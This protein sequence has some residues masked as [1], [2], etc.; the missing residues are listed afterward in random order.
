ME[1]QKLID[2]YLKFLRLNSY[3]ERTVLR[4][5]YLLNIFYDYLI[6]N[7]ITDIT[8]ISYLNGIDPEDILNSACYYVSKGA[9]SEDTITMY[10]SVIREF[11]RYIKKEFDIGNDNLIKIFGLGQRDEN[12]FSNKFKIFIEDQLNKKTIKPSSQ[13]VPFTD[14]QVKIIVNYCNQNLTNLSADI[15]IE[16]RYYNRCVKSLAVKLIA[17]IGVSVETLNKIQIG[18]LDTD[19][20]VISIS[21]Y[22]IRLP[23]WLRRQ[24]DDFRKSILKNSANNFPLFALYNGSTISQPSILGQFISRKLRDEPDVQNPYSLT[25]L[26]K[27]AIMQLIDAELDRDMIIE[28]TGYKD[29][30]FSSCKQI[31]DKIDEVKNELKINNAI[32]QLA[33][34]DFL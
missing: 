16:E 3:S 21:G 2:E 32:K 15:N 13:G 9:S 34:Y 25:S 29:E 12:A 4:Y 22:K 28:L 27:Y 20:G 31:L 10:V 8:L 19:M 5:N 17:Y 6:L 24:L 14:E 18:H 26:A 33:T 30:I 7:K 11:F 1:L 23:F